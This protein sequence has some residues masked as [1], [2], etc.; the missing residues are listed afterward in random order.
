MNKTPKLILTSLLI[1]M[2]IYILIF[3]IISKSVIE[4]KIEKFDD[5]VGDVLT[6]KELLLLQANAIT[7]GLQEIDDL[8]TV[9]V[10]EITTAR[11]QH[12]G[13]NGTADPSNHVKLIGQIMD[14]L[15]SGSHVTV[16]SNLF[17]RSYID[18]TLSS[19][20]VSFVE[21]ASLGDDFFTARCKETMSCSKDYDLTDIK[22]VVVSNLYEDMVTG[23]L[24]ITLAAPVYH[25][26]KLI[27]DL[28]YDIFPTNRIGSLAGVESYMRDEYGIRT[29]VFSDTPRG[30][31][32]PAYSRV[33]ALNNNV[34]ISYTLS[35]YKLFTDYIGWLFFIFFV[36]YTSLTTVIGRK[37]LEDEKK[38]SRVDSLTGALNRTAF[39]AISQDALLENYTVVSI[40][41]NGIKKI[42]DTFGHSVGDK[43]IK[44][45]AKTLRGAVRQNDLVFRFGGDEFVVMLKNCPEDIAANLMEKVNTQLQG[46]A[47]VPDNYVSVSYGVAKVSNFDSLE[48]ALSFADSHMYTN[49]NERKESAQNNQH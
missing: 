8:S 36:V 16:V 24:S 32:T 25:K 19:Y 39:R 5:F 44:K 43:A 23:K 14:S 7:S 33:Y 17:Y 18:N 15:V 34:L 2:A 1:S 20:E 42:N 6:V 13:A 29:I 22:G 21:E 40:D 3:S 30:T 10:T 4:D 47:V 35:H 9:E 37:A 38:L 48:D 31:V 11:I 41:G 28:S 26:G 27:G 45:I 46:D 49:K 12:I